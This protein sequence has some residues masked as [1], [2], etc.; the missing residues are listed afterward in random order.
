MKFHREGKRSSTDHTLLITASADVSLEF[1]FVDEYHLLAV[2]M[3]ER[4]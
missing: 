2:N 3:L 4:M 1:K